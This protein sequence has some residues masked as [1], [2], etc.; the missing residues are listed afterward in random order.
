MEAISSGRLPANIWMPGTWRHSL[1]QYLL[2][3]HTDV[4]YFLEESQGRKLVL[5]N[6]AWKWHLFLRLWCITYVI[7][8]LIEFIKLHTIAKS[9]K[10]R[11][12]RPVTSGLLQRT[13]AYD[14]FSNCTAFFDELGAGYMYLCKH[15]LGENMN[16]WCDMM[17]LQLLWSLSTLSYS[18]QWSPALLDHIGVAK[19]LCHYP[20]RM[21]SLSPK[22]TSLLWLWISWQILRGGNIGGALLLLS[23]G[24]LG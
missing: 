14:P 13:E 6:H 11:S 12:F 7:T 20:L 1:Y 4:G 21:Q 17:E 18:Q 8:I 9:S 2:C 24:R 22:A 3:I 16:S 23:I 15:M 19:N 10:D 5:S